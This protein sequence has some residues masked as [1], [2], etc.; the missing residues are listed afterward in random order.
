MLP[1]CDATRTERTGICAS[2]ECRSDVR[3]CCGFDG[4]HTVGGAGE[5]CKCVDEGNAGDGGKE[6]N[7]DI[8]KSV[9]NG[10]E[11]E[12]GEGSSNQPLDI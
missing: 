2:R 8:E 12:E 11:D 10:Q 4:I 5:H 9:G 3:L 1:D 6:P 7:I